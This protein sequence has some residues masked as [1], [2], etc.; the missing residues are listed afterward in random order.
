MIGYEPNLGDPIFVD[1]QNLNVY[2]AERTW[3]GCLYCES[4]R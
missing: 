1:I 4:Y 2:A 3:Y